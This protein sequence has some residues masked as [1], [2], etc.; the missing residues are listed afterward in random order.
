[1]TV[2]KYDIKIICVNKKNYLRCEKLFTLIK[3]CIYVI[4]WI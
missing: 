3:Q 4:I 2:E 1:M